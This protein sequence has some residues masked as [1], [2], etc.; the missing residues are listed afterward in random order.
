LSSGAVSK[1]CWALIY[2]FHHWVRSDER[3]NFRVDNPMNLDTHDL[4]KG[5]TTQNTVINN[6]KTTRG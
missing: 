4:I 5:D 1:C 6:T 3:D 2:V